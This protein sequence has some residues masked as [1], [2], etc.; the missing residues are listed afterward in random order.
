[1]SQNPDLV[2]CYSLGEPH[3]ES[4][5]RLDN[6]MTSENNGR[7]Y[8]SHVVSNRVIR[9][10]PVK[11]DLLNAWVVSESKIGTMSQCTGVANNFGGPV[12]QK[13]VVVKHGISKYFSP[14]LF[15]SREARPDVII[16]CGFRS[17]SHVIKMKRAFKSRPF[18]VHLQ[19]PRVSGYDLVF[20]SNHD[21]TNEFDELPQYERMVGVPHRLRAEEI[22]LRRENARRLYNPQGRKIASVFVGGSNG[23]YVYDDRAISG[24]Q[25]AIR[26]LAD[27][28]WQVLVS[29]SRRSDDETLRRLREIESPTVTVWDRC[30]PNPYIDYVAAAD[31]FLITKDSV[32]MPCEALVTGRPVY[33]LDLS[34][35]PGDRLVKFERFHRDLRETLKLTRSFEGRLEAYSYSPLNEAKRIARVIERR[36]GFQP[37]PLTGE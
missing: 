25:D 1:M 24:I 8:V 33:S 28:D 32:T 26:T 3:L 37:G 20:V 34:A 5:R 11:S 6:N 29:T 18:I 9:M 19:R 22:L 7:D 15:S 4:V 17:E 31:A 21:W 12:L 23:A 36:I 35:V 16:S 10:D 27:G 14:R 2:S 30:E 13:P